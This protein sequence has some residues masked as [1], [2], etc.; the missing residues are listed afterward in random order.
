MELTAIVS[1][2]GAAGVGGVSLA[3]YGPKESEARG[4]K[5][6]KTRGKTFPMPNKKFISLNEIIISLN[7][8]II[9]LNEMAISFNETNFFCGLAKLLPRS[10]GT[11]LPYDR[12]I[13]LWH[14][15]FPS[16]IKDSDVMEYSG[17]FL[18]ESRYG[19]PAYKRAR[20]K[21]TDEPPPRC[22]RTFREI[23]LSG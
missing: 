20:R 21:L 23:R 2:L 22:C 1:A 5:V 3:D 6:S 9:S 12:V 11:F 14:R 15:P 8:I 17:L 4:R 13:R 10:S 19:S 16:G 7:E 18:S